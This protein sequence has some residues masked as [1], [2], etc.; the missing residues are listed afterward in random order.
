[1]WHKGVVGFPDPARGDYDDDDDD[2]DDD[3]EYYDGDDNGGIFIMKSIMM[4]MNISST[5]ITQLLN[6][7]I[8]KRLKKSDTQYH[9]PDF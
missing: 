1:M 8:P 5:N 4:M 2:D 9:I 3:D 6:T 7:L